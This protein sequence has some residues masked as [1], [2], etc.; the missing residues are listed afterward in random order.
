MQ[1]M[2]RRNQV[3]EFASK[4]YTHGDIAKILHVDRSVISRD[5][6][7]LNQ[8]AKENVQKYIDVKL[9]A[10]YEKC[11][12][13]L[14]SILKESW[15]M[16]QQQDIERPE[17]I[18]ALSLAKECYTTKLELLTNST[19]LQSAIKFVAEK[20]G[21]LHNNSKNDNDDRQSDN[22]QGQKSDALRVEPQQRH[23]EQEIQ[24]SEASE[25]SELIEEPETE[26]DDDTE[27]EV[28]ESE[29]DEETT[30]TVTED[31]IF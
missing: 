29:A 25:E 21:Q 12:M 7:Y 28:I 17:K 22:L 13:G 14:T 31:Q 26:E 18:Q 10:E 3:L 20:Q 9:P 16:A 6:T 11:I 27:Q 1:M 15:D 23:Q 5:I 19:I 2:W 8:Q 4:G 30:T 24:T